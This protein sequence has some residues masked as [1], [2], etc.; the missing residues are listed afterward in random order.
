L[1]KERSGTCFEGRAG[2][3]VWPAGCGSLRIRTSI[4]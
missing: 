2:R 1:K 4:S 3:G